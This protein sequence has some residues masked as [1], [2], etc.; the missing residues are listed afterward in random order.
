[1]DSLPLGWM[2]GDWRLA[3]MTVH[4]KKRPLSQDDLLKI[5]DPDPVAAEQK[6]LEVCLL[7]RRYFEW[8]QTPDPDDMVQETLRRVFERL[9]G[10]QKIT[11]EN[12]I[13]YFMGFAQNL[14]REGWKVR[15]SEPLDE[16]LLSKSPPLFRTLNRAEQKIFLRECLRKLSNEDVELL[17]ASLERGNI[18]T[19]AEKQGLGFAAVRVRLYR[20]RKRLQEFMYGQEKQKG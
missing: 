7:L 9:Q 4:N 20:I 1:M 16:Q 6:Y 15:K 3:L 13:S 10:G 5:L 12:P 14:V 18:A 2:D 11:T 19:W 8:R 17:A